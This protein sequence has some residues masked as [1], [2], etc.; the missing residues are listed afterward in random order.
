MSRR[1]TY[2]CSVDRISRAMVVRRSVAHLPIKTTALTKGRGR[3]DARTFAAVGSAVAAP[4]P[5]SLQLSDGPYHPRV[6]PPHSLCS[7]VL[8][9]AINSGLFGG[10]GFT[11]ESAESVGVIEEVTKTATCQV[12]A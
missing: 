12:C 11:D 9:L 5:E 2:V 3:G 7:E 1:A 10:G 4:S 8:E 6:L